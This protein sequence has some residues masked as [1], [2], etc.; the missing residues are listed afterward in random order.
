MLSQA[1]FSVVGNVKRRASIAGD[2]GIFLYS[3]LLFLY[4]SLYTCTFVSGCEH[5]WVCFLQSRV[6]AHWGTFKTL[7]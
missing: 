2:Y 6:T 5:F 7:T 4:V 1:G 3:L